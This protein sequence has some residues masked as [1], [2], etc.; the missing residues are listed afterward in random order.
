V[1]W[2]HVYTHV[3]HMCAWCLKS[4]NWALNLQKLELRKLVCYMWLLG[5]ESRP[6]GKAARALNHWV[7]SPAP[8]PPFWLLLSFTGHLGPRDPVMAYG[9]AVQRYNKFKHSLDKNHVL[10]KGDLSQV[11][12]PFSFLLGIRYCS[13]R[14]HG[15]KTQPPREGRGRRAFQENWVCDDTCG[16]GATRENQCYTINRTRRDRIPGA[17]LH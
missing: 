11:S 14:P 7:T 9:S 13:K 6:F 15:N 2:L 12:K 3:H 10:F 4:Q 1:F 5:T 8:P 16:I 17:V